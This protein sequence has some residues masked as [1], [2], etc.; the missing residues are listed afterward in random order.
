MT[1]NTITLIRPNMGDWRSTDAFTPLALGI[2]AARTP[3]GV[4]VRFYDERL[5]PIP[6]DDQPD[7]AALSVETFTAHR[8]YTIA[9]GYR[10]R[11]VTVILGGYHPTAL[12]D[13]ALQ[14]AD[15]VVIG[16]AEGC[17]EQLLADFQADRLEQRYSGGNARALE[18]MLIDRTIFA[19]KRYVPIEVVQ[20]TRGCRFACDFC[21]IH[22]F[23]GAN[24]RTRPTADLY[25][26]LRTFNRRRLLFFADDNLFCSRERLAELLAMLVPLKLRW[27]CQISIDASRDDD[28]LDQLKAAGCKAVLIGFESL[29]AANLKQMGKAWSKSDYKEVVRRLHQR[30]IAVY[31]TFVFGYD[32][33]TTESIERSLEFALDA[34]LDIVNLNPLTPMPGSTLYKRLFDEGRL[35]EPDGRWWL[36]PDYRYGTPIF[37][38]RGMSA[39]AMS[40]A[41]YAAKRRF[42]EWR[43]IVRRAGQHLL[44]GNLFQA[45]IVA[46]ANIIS[47]REVLAKQYR[48]FIGWKHGVNETHA[49]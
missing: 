29:E 4:E 3:A 40:E 32:A 9:D 17:W 42:Y 5:E 37:T 16:D 8:A 49:S 27:A 22:A 23:Y 13:E 39:E 48:P 34:N 46:L 11:G 41:C 45:G 20:F 44:R 1:L 24:L 21:S 43:Y 31:G 33:D 30:S 47:R 15:A 18:T 36:N 6:A 38:P 14:H 35:V 2:L 26:E 19:G 12:P 25:A 10:S 7:I 28:L